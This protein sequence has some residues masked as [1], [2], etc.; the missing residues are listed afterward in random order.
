[1]KKKILAT[2]LGLLTAASS[3]AAS[4]TTSQTNLEQKNNS[5]IEK[6]DIAY[7]GEFLQPKVDT[8]EANADFYNLAIIDYKLDNG[9]KLVLQPRFS[10]VDSAQDRFV[11]YDL[12]AGIKKSFTLTDKLSLFSQARVQLPTSKGSQA[13]DTLIMGVRTTQLL[14]AK[15]DDFNSLTAGGT[16]TKTLRTK[17]NSTV[18]EYS[19]H[20]LLPYISYVNSAM[21][22]KFALRVDLEGYLAHMAGK[23]D[24]HFKNVIGGERIIIGP[25]M[26]IAGT[27]IYPYLQHDPS[28]VKAIDQAGAGVQIYRK[29]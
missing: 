20:N 15:I 27:S 9:A 26:N 4:T 11:E 8:E 6:I 23:S 28:G 19:R 24:L 22:E 12:R 1:M 21:S 25:D 14:T 13:D 10:L 16:I 7:F 17:A 5:L 3:I 29:F 2:T 18:D